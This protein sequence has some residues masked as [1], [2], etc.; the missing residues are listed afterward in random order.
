[1]PCPYLEGGVFCQAEEAGIK[2]SQGF[3]VSGSQL[4]HCDEEAKRNCKYMRTVFVEMTRRGWRP[5]TA[6]KM[7]VA[8]R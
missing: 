8:G 7:S 5:N 1:M 6:G 2:D 4:L 3:E